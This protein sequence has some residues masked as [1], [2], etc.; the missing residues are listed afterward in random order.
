MLMVA[1]AAVV[2]LVAACGSSSKKSATI[3]GAGSTL[4]AP[5]YMQWGSSVKSQGVTLNYAAVGSGAGVAQFTAG[6]TNFAASDPPLKD[7]EEAALKKGT[8]VHVPTVLG[9]ITVSYNLPGAKSGLKLD[10]KTIA[11]IFLG[12]VKK[13]ND[14]E[15]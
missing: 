5:I 9:A 8:P 3:N 1:A 4:A 11:D 2:P 10:G 15:I 7:S 6:T 14:P 12:K 13:W